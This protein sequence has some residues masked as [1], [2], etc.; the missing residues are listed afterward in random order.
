MGKPVQN[1][2]LVE[3]GVKPK[4][5]DIE[6]IENYLQAKGN[7]EKFPIVGPGKPKDN[8]EKFP[9]IAPGK[10]KKNKGNPTLP[11]A[12]TKLILK[13]GHVL[14]PEKGTVGF[15]VWFSVGNGLGYWDQSGPV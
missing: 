3:P 6:T 9:I 8:L 14:I 10:S 4:K 1:S 2:K 11:K 5:E 13:P 15:G 12:R 7:L